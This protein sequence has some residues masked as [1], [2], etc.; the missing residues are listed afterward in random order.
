LADGSKR[1]DD[2]LAGQPDER[3]GAEELGTSRSNVIWCELVG[4]L[5]GS[6]AGGNSSGWSP[7]TRSRHHHAAQAQPVAER[8]VPHRSIP[9]WPSAPRSRALC[10]TGRLVG[11]ARQPRSRRPCGSRRHD[12]AHVGPR[13]S[14]ALP[15]RRPLK[16]MA[17]HCRS[18]GDRRRST[19]R[20][21]ATKG[22][23]SIA[24]TSTVVNL[25]LKPLGRRHRPHRATH[26]VPTTR[27]VS[28]SGRLG[29]AART[30]CQGWP[31]ATRR[32]VALTRARTAPRCVTGGGSCCG[33]R[34][35][36]ALVRD[37]GDHADRRVAAVPVVVVDRCRHPPTASVVVG[38]CSA[39][40]SSNSRVECQDS[41]TALPSAEPGR[42][43]DW[44]MSS[45]SH[46][47]RNTGRSTRRPAR[48]ESAYAHS[49]DRRDDAFSAPTAAWRRP[50]RD[51]ATGGSTGHRRR[52]PTMT[53]S[54]GAPP[55]SKSSGWATRSRVPSV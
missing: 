54:G 48:C 50:G 3:V 55:Y 11:A 44:V 13:L 33:F 15:G 31:E 16:A 20:R 35:E 32:A 24:V 1:G 5:S 41:I 36:A 25:L 47:A 2:L 46:A 27:H 4:S 49:A 10:R 38:K 26:H 28:S 17:R 45:R 8:R 51:A 42:P 12:N 18:P 40:R 37:R 21:A 30:R 7:V 6:G 43:M 52:S 14:P 22:R 19:G 23:A 9:R 29:G 39:R 34:V 53:P